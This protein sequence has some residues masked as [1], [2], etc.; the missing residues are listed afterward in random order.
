MR[1]IVLLLAFVLLTAASAL[2]R[3]V[4]EFTVKDGFAS[5]SFALANTEMRLFYYSYQDKG[6][7][8]QRSRVFTY[9]PTGPAP[10][11]S[12]VARE[13][14]AKAVKWLFFNE[15]AR[16]DAMHPTKLPQGIVCFP[17]VLTSDGSSRD[18]LGMRFTLDNGAIRK[19]EVAACVACGLAA[20]YI[21]D[22]EG[23]KPKK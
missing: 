2:A 22:Y 14:I 13:E 20:S 17:M 12:P 5:Y 1:K 18:G 4:N 10:L 15:L 8:D 23:K 3:P 21:K 7:A 9:K 19:V 16:V 11:D 6:M